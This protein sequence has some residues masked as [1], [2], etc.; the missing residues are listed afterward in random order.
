MS[1]VNTMN[2]PECYRVLNI[3]T[4]VN[5][6]EVK[7]A[8][9]ALALKFHPDHNPG[10]EE[11]ETRFKEI[12][13]AFKVLEYHYRSSRKQ[14]YEFSFEKHFKD[15]TLDGAC[16]IDFEMTSSKKNSF[17]RSI[18]G[19]RIDK[20]LVAEL[21]NHLVHS[22]GQFEKQ[23]F[24]MDVEKEIKID[25]STILKGSFVR[26]RQNRENFEVPIPQG[27]W[28]RMKVR[29]NNKGE[30]SWFS[31]K[32]G[33]LLLDIQVISS[34]CRNYI[35]ERDLYYNFPVSMAS[36][37][38]GKM[39]TLMTAQGVIKFTLPRNTTNGKT[40]VLKAKE[41]TGDLPST[42]HIIKIQLKD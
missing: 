33:D 41:K 6:I 37:H 2:L 24:Q 40:F 12:S 4:D 18:I 16:N 36:I 9:R 26:V 42:K 14:E 5:W 28:N 30:S 20:E 15:D 23:A 7:K 17:F 29:I 34:D 22:L 27:A 32:R 25:S 13:R 31:K 19:R 39:H 8:Y 35:G 10:I 3:S 11:C 21:K 1:Y 38:E